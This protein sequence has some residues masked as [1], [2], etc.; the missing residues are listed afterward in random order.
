MKR[1][2]AKYVGK[3]RGLTNLTSREYKQVK[4]TVVADDLT[5]VVVTHSLSQLPCPI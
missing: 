3:S 2:V 4:Q 1:E 5:R